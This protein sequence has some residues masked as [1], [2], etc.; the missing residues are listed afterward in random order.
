MDVDP[1]AN[2][3]LLDRIITFF[4]TPKTQTTAPM[5]L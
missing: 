1:L 5:R 4:V 3:L 2:E